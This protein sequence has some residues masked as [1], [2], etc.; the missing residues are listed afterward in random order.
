[1]PTSRLVDRFQRHLNYLRVSITDRCN[2]RCRYCVPQGNRQSLAHRDILRYEEIL[3]LVRIGVT[4]GIT[5][6][7][8]TG[9]EPL[10]RKGVDAF[11]AALTRIEGLQ[12]VSLTTNGVLLDKHLAKIKAAG[13]KRLNLSLDTLDPQKYCQITGF[14]EFERVWANLGRARDFGFAPI[15]VNVVA[16][17]GF[18]DD[19]LLDIAKLSLE[20]PYH[21]RFIEYMPM[22]STPMDSSQQ[23]LAP[24]ILDRLSALGR[25]QLVTPGRNDGPAQRYRFEGAPG[26]IGIIHAISHHFCAS[27]N[28]LRLTATGQLRPCLLSDY[29][30]DLKGPLRR[31]CLDPVLADVFRKATHFKAF[32]HQIAPCHRER[33]ATQMT[34]IGG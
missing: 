3:R 25:L 10:V 12:D 6:V 7:R 27:C 16:I 23:L 2:L 30:E 21:I 1:M 34:S 13:I 20:Y 19:E 33:V 22:G 31:G 14:D 17:K 8:V 5:K 11:L 28:R 24:E 32:E 4:L 26:E 18:N 29:Q 15:K 9:G